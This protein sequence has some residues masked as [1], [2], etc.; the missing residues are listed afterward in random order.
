M[1]DKLASVVERYDLTARFLDNSAIAA[2]TEYLN[3]GQAR[4]QAVAMIN[5]NAVE[6]VREAARQLFEELPYLIQPGGNAY[7]TRRHAMYLR[8]MDYF[9]RYGSYALLTGDNSVLDERLLAGLRDT[10][11][12]LGIPLG[13][14]ALSIQLMK[15]RI[16]EK[17]AGAGLENTGLVDEP[18]DYMIRELS[19]TDV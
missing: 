7:T 15:N 2:V 12:S 4:I 6:I 14:T 17:M 3:T 8:D 16:K 10:F 1:R 11:N 13:P 5:A 19:E 18:F 9:L